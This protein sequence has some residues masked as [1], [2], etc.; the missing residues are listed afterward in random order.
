[1]G[2]SSSGVDAA[3]YNDVL[4]RY[5]QRRASFLTP[6]ACIYK[7]ARAARLSGCAVCTRSSRQHRWPSRTLARDIRSA[8][9]YS[10]GPRYRFHHRLSGKGADAQMAAPGGDSPGAAK[11]KAKIAGKRP[12][13]GANKRKYNTTSAAQ[14][15]VVT[16]RGLA[17]APR[18]Q[19][20]TGATRHAEAAPRRGAAGRR[21]APGDRKLNAKR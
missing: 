4:L 9:K 10:T 11:T 16:A 15:G 21:E 18:T 7:V 13:K 20:K 17:R 19:A 14:G 8:G 6:H 3:C 1:M 5:S 2:K 12:P